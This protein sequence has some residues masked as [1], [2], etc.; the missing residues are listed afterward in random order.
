MT[1]YQ[2][3]LGS[4]SLFSR[5]YCA[6]AGFTNKLARGF[7]ISEHGL[8][9]ACTLKTG[10]SLVLDLIRSSGNGVGFAAL[11]EVTG[12]DSQ[13]LEEMLHELF[14]RGQIMVGQGGAYVETKPLPSEA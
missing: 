14:Q 3:V 2:E 10:T 4:G 9:D 12:H 6:L 7:N 5:F 13:K 8:N 11:S 1:V